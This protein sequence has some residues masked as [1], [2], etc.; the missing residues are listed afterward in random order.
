MWVELLTKR[1]IYQH[2]NE[3]NAVFYRC[4]PKK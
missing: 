1:V 2:F 3:F 4:L